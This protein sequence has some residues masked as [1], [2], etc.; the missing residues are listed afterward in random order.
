MHFLLIPYGL[1]GA[2]FILHFHQSDRRVG[3]SGLVVVASTTVVL[4]VLAMM[5]RPVAGDSWRYYQYFLSIREA[6]LLEVLGNE[7]GD[8]LFTVLNW[9]A[10]QFGDSQLW[11]FG[12]TLLLFVGGFV[13]ALHR[14]LPT[15]EAAAVLMCYAAYPFFIAYGANGLRQGLALACML[16]SLVQFSRGEKW[17]GWLWLLPIPFW[18][19]GSMLGA[20]IVAIFVLMN[21]WVPSERARWVLVLSVYLL[22]M[23]M[24]LSGLNSA[25]IAL[26]P[27]F[28]DFETR[29]EIYFMDTSQVGLEYRTG[30]RPDFA[31]F[32]LLPLMTALMLRKSGA[33][34][35]K[36]AGWWLAIYL[37]L[38]SVYHLFSFAPF[39]DRFASYSWFLLPLVLY[40][41]VRGTGSRSLRSLFLLITVAIN[42]LM[43]QFYTGSFLPSPEWLSLDV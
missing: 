41:Q 3:D 43:L 30:F 13:W 39:A 28:F 25:T 24:S 17:S 18:H 8:F 11:L 26:L 36:G 31:I 32:S 20:V 10:A 7:Q 4:L 16:M 12:A 40:F 35:F 6:G 5:F 34:S 9:L 42:L 23:L 37:S 19:G 33:F 27:D 2:M 1:L 15:T 21:R 29:H 22:A 14:L 38:N